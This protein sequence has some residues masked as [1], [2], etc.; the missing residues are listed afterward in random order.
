MQRRDG[1]RAQVP[2]QAL[3]GDAFGNPTQAAPV[4]PAEKRFWLFL[5]RLVPCLLGFLQL[6]AEP[7][8]HARE[9][10]LSPGSTV[11]SSSGAS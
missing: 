9:E 7:V 11:S 8:A 10:A 6:L 5:R 1:G 4:H 3:L 2:Q